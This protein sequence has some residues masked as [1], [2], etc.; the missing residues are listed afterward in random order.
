MSSGW[1]RD[2]QRAP[3]SIPSGTLP[4]STRSN[5]GEDEWSM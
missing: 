3:G 4:P 5:I 2:S 1:M